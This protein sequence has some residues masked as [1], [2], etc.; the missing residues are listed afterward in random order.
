MPYE[1]LRSH[2]SYRHFWD[3]SG[4]SFIDFLVSH[5]RCRL[6]GDGLQSA[7]GDI[8]LGGRFFLTDSTE[9]ADTSGSHSRV[10]RMSCTFTVSVRRPLP[11]FEHMGTDR[12]PVRRNGSVPG[13]ELRGARSLGEGKKGGRTFRFPHRRSRIR[14]AISASLWTRLKA[15]ISRLLA[16]FAMVTISRSSACLQTSRIERDD[17]LNGM[18]K[19]RRSSETRN[20]ANTSRAHSAGRGT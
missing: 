13:D 1:P 8:V 3:Y 5:H 18:T 7:E 4:G 15:G 10:S 20:R 2:G 14:Q 6:L 12:L 19:T 11:G 9:T 17:A 16:I